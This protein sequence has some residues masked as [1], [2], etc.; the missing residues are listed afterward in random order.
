MEAE[1]GGRVRSY[2]HGP[3]PKQNRSSTRGSG[4]QVR[5]K[6]LIRYFYE[7]PFESTFMNVWVR[8][9]IALSGQN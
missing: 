6:K 7:S 1:S 8:H 4:R 2:S 9:F 3:S 5:P